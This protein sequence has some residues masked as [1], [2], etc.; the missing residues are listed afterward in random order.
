MNLA[1]KTEVFRKLSQALQDFA[2]VV[3]FQHLCLLLFGAW[4]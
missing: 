2:D 4:E 3:M 1:R